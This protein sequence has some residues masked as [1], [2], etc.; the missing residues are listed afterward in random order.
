MPNIEIESKEAIN[1]VKLYWDNMPSF[2][3]ESNMWVNFIS[4]HHYRE[5]VVQL[6]T[7]KISQTFI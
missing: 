2:S 3:L 7:M 4:G 5:A 6:F 1:D